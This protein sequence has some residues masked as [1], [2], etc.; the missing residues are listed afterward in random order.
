MNLHIWKCDVCSRFLPFVLIWLISSPSFTHCYEYM[1]YFSYKKFDWYSNDI[2]FLWSLVKICGTEVERDT[3]PPYCDT[4]IPFE[5][6]QMHHLKLPDIRRTLLPATRGRLL[7]R[8]R[9]LWR[10][11]PAS[12]SPAAQRVTHGLRLRRRRWRHEHGKWSTHSALSWDVTK[13]NSFPSLEMKGE[14]F[15]NFTQVLI[16][17][18]IISCDE[19]KPDVYSNSFFEIR[20][21][22]YSGWDDDRR[23]SR[24]RQQ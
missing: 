24:Q 6:I 15:I 14:M 23:Y 9:G 3:A 20:I 16:E 1:L 17:Q 4:L 12:A 2:D 11:R 5:K 18:S 19:N 21:V 10:R 13:F 22:S 7:R 8:L